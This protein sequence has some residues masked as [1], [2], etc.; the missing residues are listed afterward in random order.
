MAAAHDK[1]GNQARSVFN[2]AVEYGAMSTLVYGFASEA[3][4]A[5]DV[6]SKFER[7]MVEVTKVMDPLYQSQELL[8]ESAKTEFSV[9]ILL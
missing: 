3:K 6:M 5:I 2:K 4:N 1:E 7:Q 8:T 9:R